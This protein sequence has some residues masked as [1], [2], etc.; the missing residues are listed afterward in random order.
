MSVRTLAD[1]ERALTPNVAALALATDTPIE[2]CEGAPPRSSY[3]LRAAWTVSRIT[4]GVGLCHWRKAVN[5]ADCR[6]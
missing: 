1:L 2:N 5:V 4:C 6:E 3:L